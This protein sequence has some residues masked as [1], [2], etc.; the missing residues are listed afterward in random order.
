MVEKWA[1]LA[2]LHLWGWFLVCANSGLVG[3]VTEESVWGVVPASRGQG[4]APVVE[5]QVGP[6]DKSA[7]PRRCLLLTGGPWLGTCPLHTVVE[8]LHPVLAVW[9]GK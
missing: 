8:C 6:R 9:L 7:G 1:V 3:E 2:A 4:P 5:G